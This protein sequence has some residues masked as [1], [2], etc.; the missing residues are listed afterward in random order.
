MRRL[1]QQHYSTLLGLHN[2]HG[3]DSSAA[4]LVERMASEPG[5]DPSDVQYT[6]YWE[7][8]AGAV[9]KRG[10]SKT[11]IQHC[12]QELCSIMLCV[13]LSDPAMELMVEDVGTKT[14][15]DEQCKTLTLDGN[16]KRRSR[17]V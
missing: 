2:K 12:V 15:F 16:C 17:S 1:L 4:A 14:K 5:A 9:N 6:K 13:R 11:S 7:F 3:P 10:A 8:R